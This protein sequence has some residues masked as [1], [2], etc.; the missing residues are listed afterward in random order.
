ME[1]AL[2]FA[3]RDSRSVTRMGLG[4]AKGDARPATEVIE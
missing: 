2:E 3:P 4:S 1:F